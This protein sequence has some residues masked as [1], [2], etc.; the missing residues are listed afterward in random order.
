MGSVTDIK[1]FKAAKTVIYDNR[2]RGLISEMVRL[3][4]AQHSFMNDRDAAMF[5]YGY[6]TRSNFNGRIS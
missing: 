5:V 4:K 2:I 1:R 6:L 3:V